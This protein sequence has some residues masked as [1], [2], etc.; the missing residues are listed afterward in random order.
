VGCA[1]PRFHEFEVLHDQVE[2][3]SGRRLSHPQSRP[4]FSDDIDER[5]GFIVSL[6]ELVSLIR[7]AS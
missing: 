7:R 4:L 1:E 3:A 5:V 6:D 2:S